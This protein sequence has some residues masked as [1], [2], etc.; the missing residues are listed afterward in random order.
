MCSHLPLSFFERRT[1][2][3]ALHTYC[4]CPLHRLH[5]PPPCLLRCARTHTRA[6]AH[7]NTH[8]TERLQAFLPLLPTQSPQVHPRLPHFVCQ[9]QLKLPSGV[10]LRI[11]SR[12]NFVLELHPKRHYV[13]R[14]AHGRTACAQ[15][16]CVVHTRCRHNSQ[17]FCALRI[18]NKH[19]RL[20]KLH[21]TTKHVVCLD[22][23]LAQAIKAFVWRTSPARTSASTRRTQ[24]HGI[25][26]VWTIALPLVQ[27][28]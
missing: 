3:L 1:C 19:I 23:S 12:H 13:M 11:P 9:V 20:L 5:Q 18:L 8:N 15:S 17:S 21:L 4:R 26:F 22:D 10:G 24:H 28:L 27:S 14:L 7:K 25:V 2:K 16:F 6:R